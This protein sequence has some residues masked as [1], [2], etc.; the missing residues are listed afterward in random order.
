MLLLG[1]MGSR[2]P[3]QVNLQVNAQALHERVC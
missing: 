2:V 3:V 1:E